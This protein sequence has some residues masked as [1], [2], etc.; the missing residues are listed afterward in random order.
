MSFAVDLFFSFRSPYSYLALT[1]TRRMVDM[2]DVVVRLRPVYPL[3]VRI[4]NFFK[5]ANPNFA[6]YVYLDSARVALHDGVP[7]RLP[8]PDPVVQ[9][10]TTFEVAAEQPLIKRLTRL[11]AATQV[12][13][14]SLEFAEAI[15]RVLW[16]GSTN[17]WNE[18]DHLLFAA[19]RAGFNLRKLDAAIVDNPRR[20]DDVIASNEKDHAATGHWGVPTF[21][22]EGEPFF[23]QDRIDHLI[24]RL[25]GQGMTKRS[26]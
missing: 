8:R 19:L 2:Y 6:K 11:A 24:W 4:P 10:M 17:G 20:Y 15:S 22:Y 14:R 16:D 7:F 23:G 13:G 1:K 26:D 5:N 25:Q 18:G 12:E 21:A 3:A 9:D